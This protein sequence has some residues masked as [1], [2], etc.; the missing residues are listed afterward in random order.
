MAQLPLLCYTSAGSDAANT[1][2]GVRLRFHNEYSTSI[3]RTA[4]G[5]RYTSSVHHE[6]TESVVL[7]VKRRQGTRDGKFFLDYLEPEERIEILEK[8]LAY[9]RGRLDY[10]YKLQQVADEASAPAHAQRV[11]AFHTQQIRN[12]YQWIA[13]W[14]EEIRASA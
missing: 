9:V 4:I 5:I 6:G 13:T 14:L 11:L 10:L 12:E 8:R 2:R 3:L 1:Q 7:L